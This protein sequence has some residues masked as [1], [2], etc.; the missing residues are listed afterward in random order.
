MRWLRLLLLAWCS[1]CSL[2][3]QFDPETQPCDSAGACSAGYFCS[4]AGLCTS[5]DGG[6]DGRDAGNSDASVCTARETACGDGRD[7]DCDNQVDCA[8]S[9]CGGV[10]CDDRD[11]CTTGEVCTGGVCPRGTAVVCNSPPN[12]CQAMT[13]SCV[14][15]TGMCRYNPL[16][17]GTQCG[18]GAA[19]RCCTGEC[20]DT[21]A[22][23]MN[24]GGCGLACAGSQVCQPLDRLTCGAASGTSG[25][26]TCT[27]TAPCPTGVSDAGS[28]TCNTTAGNCRPASPAQCA[29]GQL[30]ST[31]GGVCG[32]FCR[33]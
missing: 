10:S 11:L 15:S 13:G 14:T 30:L 4:D 1:G 17:D 2:L 21:S 29:P 24:C 32:A 20:I 22:D 12:A 16:A 6:F 8:D 9:D 26:C 28:Q 5:Y 33:Y 27:A 7:N 25:R 31:D 19:S 23:A 18:T 3:V